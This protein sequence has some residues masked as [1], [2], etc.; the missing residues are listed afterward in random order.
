MKDKDRVLEIHYQGRQHTIRV[1]DQL[2]DEY[3]EDIYN[4]FVKAISYHKVR[5]FDIDEIEFVYCLVGNIVDKHLAGVNLGIRRGTKQFAPNTKVY[6]FPNYMSDGYEKV[7][8]MGKPRKKR[9]L[10]KVVV[11]SKFIKNWRLAKVY[12]PQIISEMIENWGWSNSEDD[13]K[14]IEQM[15]KWLPETTVPELPLTDGE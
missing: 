3:V 10:I 7:I 6:C 8:V 9:G 2:T 13:K 12:E 14:T 11:K 15:V 1:P 4:R 5:L